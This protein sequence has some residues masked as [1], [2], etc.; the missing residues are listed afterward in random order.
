M[1][2]LV[3]NREIKKYLKNFD[4]KFWCWKNAGPIFLIS[5]QILDFQALGSHDKCGHVFFFL[6]IFVLWPQICR[7]YC[8]K[9][10]C[11]PLSCI[12]SSAAAGRIIYVPQ[13][14]F[15]AKIIIKCSFVPVFSLNISLGQFLWQGPYRIFWFFHHRFDIRW[16]VHTPLIGRICKIL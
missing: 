14:L 3:K 6:Q 7:I 10:T 4:Q 16:I 15:C 5:D 12:I 2:I 13:G 9:S 8:L 1:L 11:Y